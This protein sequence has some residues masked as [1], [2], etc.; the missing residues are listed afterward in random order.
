MWFGGD[1]DPGGAMTIDFDA[2]KQEPIDE[3]LVGQEWTVGPDSVTL[4]LESTQYAWLQIKKWELGRS[5][6]PEE[7]LDF[8]AARDALWPLLTSEEQGWMVSEWCGA[9]PA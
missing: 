6:T 1:R 8:V 7:E 4:D 9:A 5:L 2:W 3:G